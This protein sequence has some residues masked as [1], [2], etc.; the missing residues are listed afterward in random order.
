MKNKERAKACVKYGITDTL[1]TTLA[2]TVL[3]EMIAKPLS[4][5]FSLSG[6]ASAAL[7]DVCAMATRTASLGYI[8]MGFTVAIQGVLQALGYAGKPLILSF[9]RLILFVFPIA[10]LFTLSENVLNLIWWTFPIAE[11]LTCIFAYIFLKNATKH[12][13]DTLPE[14]VEKGV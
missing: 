12:K 9:F 5:L 11:V 6:G 3:F 2:L 4:M 13:I 7:V 8:F 10:Y 14:S 1:I